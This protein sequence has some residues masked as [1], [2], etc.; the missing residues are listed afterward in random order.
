MRPEHMPRRIAPG[1]KRAAGFSLIT[2]VVIVLM[3]T[4]VGLTA[5]TVSR[6][7]LA[8]AGSAQ[9]Q[10]A[11]LQEADR[12]V[13]TAESW[14]LDGTNPKSDGFTT[15]ST[16]TPALY[17][18]DHMAS[19]SLD[20]LT[21]TWNDT[22][23]TPLNGGTSRY[24]IE[25]VARRVLPLGES[26]RDLIDEEGRTDCKVVDL[27]RITSRGTSAAG[28]SRTVQSVFSVNGC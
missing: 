6:S 10:V 9:Y 13:A 8:N 27:F 19:N 22:N 5:M 23:S 28:A 17:P 25:Q 26:Q 16:Q 12:S 7:Q 15:R 18:R 11:A 2:A 3:V 1:P 20:P 4:I 21:W 14:L 24:A